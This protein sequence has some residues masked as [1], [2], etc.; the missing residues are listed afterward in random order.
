MYVDLSYNH[1][2]SNSIYAYS[3]KKQI[4]KRSEMLN[5]TILLCSIST[6]G[7]MLFC[8]VSF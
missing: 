3:V 2:Q 7:R 5:V 1:Q 6:V 8:Q 4:L